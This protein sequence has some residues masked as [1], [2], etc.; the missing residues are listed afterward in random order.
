MPFYHRN[1]MD[2]MVNLMR[3]HY[4]NQNSLGLEIVIKDYLR[5]VNA[6]EWK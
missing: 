2:T 5:L 3:T 6:W 4:K 1:I